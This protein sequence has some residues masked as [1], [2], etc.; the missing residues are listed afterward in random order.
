MSNI[1]NYLFSSCD[2]DEIN[3]VRNSLSVIVENKRD[4]ISIQSE[5][6]SLKK[7]IF[8]ICETHHDSYPKELDRY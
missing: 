3:K 2:I 8:K 6:E 7:E 5:K 1:F 4:P